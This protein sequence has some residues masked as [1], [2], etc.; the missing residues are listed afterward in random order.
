MKSQ[1]T[2]VGAH[3]LVGNFTISEI[4]IYVISSAIKHFIINLMS[5]YVNI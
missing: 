2:K 5:S 1:I 4:F 3:H